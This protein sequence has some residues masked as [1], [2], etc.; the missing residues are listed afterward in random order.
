MDRREFLRLS[1]K[2]NRSDFSVRGVSSGLTPYSGPWTVNEVS[3][4]LKRTM[5]GA[6]KSDI[7]YFLGLGMYDSV[8]ELL[9]IPPVASPPLRDY[10]LVEVD[11]V[12]YDDLGVAVGET[13]V[14]DLNMSS[15]P[16]AVG[17]INR[18]RVESLRKW[19]T[20]LMLNQNRSVAEKMLLF[21]HNHF[22]IQI[23]EV[24]DATYAYRHFQLLRDFKM[25]NV[26]ELTRLICIDPAMLMH[27]NGYLN[28]KVAPDEN[29]A[30]ELQEL[31]TIGKGVDSA[32]TEA[33]VRE[34]ARVLT[35]WR[36]NSTTLTSGIR[37]N[38]HDT[39]T[40]QFSEFYNNRSI[41]GSADGLSELQALIDMIF[42]TTECSRFICRRLYKWFVYY[43]IDQATETNVIQPL[44]DIF[45]NNNFEVL[46][47]LD[48]LFR[49]EHFYDKLNQACYIKNPFDI[50]V[51]TIR[52]LNV[53]CPPYTDYQNGYPM[54][55]NV[56]ALAERMQMNLL[57]PPD[58]S[59]WPSYYQE[60]MHYE[61]WVN[62]NS[63][64]K[65][66][67]FTDELVASGIADLRQFVA[68]AADPANPDE[69]VNHVTTYLLRYPLSDSSKTYV[70]NTFLLNGSADNSVW[71]SAWNANNNSVIVPALQNMFTFIMN[72]PEFHLC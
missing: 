38:A 29:F 37:A 50:T 36:I 68:S 20:G 22:S 16:L 13:W 17:E 12:F 45:R 26:K 7:D 70:K 2:N 3:H 72:L 62:S 64:P 67:K 66:A 27:L 63:L 59:G 41:P 31:F 5:F 43:E 34:A 69:V 8:Q 42:D 19:L 51:G 10:G 30:R 28:T 21:W 40:K 65:R 52:E 49:S 9:T 25:G 60:P 39:G 53:P 57:Q 44:A 55:Y 33:D 15:D 58:V 1:K 24:Q 4:L 35:G 46:P 54:F 47:V 18:R 14:N 61:L 32:Y 23:E 71:T 56:Y 6:K 11:G 48:T